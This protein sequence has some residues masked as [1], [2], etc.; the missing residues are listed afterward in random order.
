MV[1]PLY[2]KLPNV[3]RTDCPHRLGAGTRWADE[4]P[5]ALKDLVVAPIRFDVFKEYE[6]QAER[7]CG[8][9]AANQPCYC[10]F[11]MVQTQLCSDD[12]EVFFTEP[13]YAESITSWR[14]LDERWLVCKTTV[15][16]LEQTE[17]QSGFYL[18]NTMPR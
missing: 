6:L 17:F 9:D 7:T 11:Q 13:V 8:C 18:S 10:A 2:K 5:P 3:I 15:C 14:L 16:G 12:D 1:M 4:L